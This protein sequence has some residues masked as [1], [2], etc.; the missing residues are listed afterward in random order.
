MRAGRVVGGG[1]AAELS[2]ERIAELM[3][4]RALAPVHAR[5]SA[6]PGAPRLEVRGLAVA[7]DRGLEA[8]RGISFE[9]RGG[10]VVGIAGV[11]GN[12]QHELIECLAG[13]RRARAGEVRIDGHDITGRTPRQRFAAGLGHIPA[14]R[15]HRG[16]VPEMTLTENL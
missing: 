9:V 14:D 12:G 4:G 3:V 7:D 8:V 5:A 16:L 6:A 13:L 1:A 15:L 11:E 10:E 2:A